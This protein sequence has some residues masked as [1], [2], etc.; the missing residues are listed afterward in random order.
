MECNICGN[1]KFIDMNAR[2][3]VKCSKCYSLERTRLMALFIKKDKLVNKKTRVLHIAPEK[4]LA[5][6]L[7][8]I[9]GKNCTFV[10][11]CPEN[12]LF[13]PGI[14]KMDLCNDLELIPDKSFD[15][16]IHSHVLEHIPCNYTYVLYHLHRILSKAGRIICSIPFL[17]GSYDCSFSPELNDTERTERF[18]QNDHIRRFGRNDLQMT[19][20]KIYNLEKDYDITRIFPGEEL[21]K[22]NIPEISWKYYSPNSVLC[23]KKEAYL[24]V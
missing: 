4:G 9:A 7:Y 5:D 10:D 16:I 20:G 13:A 12:F 11:L 24:L 17:S 19:L 23:L 15:L 21:L 3:S 8:G 18:G 1:G 22:Y 6:Y 2:K 14:K